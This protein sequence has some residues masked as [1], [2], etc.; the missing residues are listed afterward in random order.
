MNNYETTALMLASC[1][2]HYE[3]V[4]ILL[5]E[6]HDLNVLSGDGT[7]ALQLA[8]YKGHYTVT[9]LLLDNNAD[10]NL[11]DYEGCTPLM[12]ASQ[13]GHYKIDYRRELLLILLTVKLE[14]H[15]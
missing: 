14:Q 8:T 9:E 13:N 4:K 3:I 7:T 10:P 6:G 5:K 11:A 2:G 1:S 15:H 12:I